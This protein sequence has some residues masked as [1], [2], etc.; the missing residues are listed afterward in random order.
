MAPESPWGAGVEICQPVN[1]LDFPLAHAAGACL[2]RGMKRIVATLAIGTAAVWADESGGQPVI[3][4]ANV[5]LVRPLDAA[6]LKR[7]AAGMPPRVVS[8]YST[9]SEPWSGWF[10][11][12]CE[13]CPDTNRHRNLSRL[14]FLTSCQSPFTVAA[15][16]HPEEPQGGRF[17]RGADGG[18]QQLTTTKDCSL[19]STEK[20]AIIVERYHTMDCRTQ[21]DGLMVPLPDAIR[22]ARFEI[23]ELTA[24]PGKD[25]RTFEIIGTEAAGNSVMT[26]EHSE[27]KGQVQLFTLLYRG[28]EAKPEALVHRGMLQRVV[29]PEG[30][31]YRQIRKEESAGPDGPLKVTQHAIESW[32]V[33]PDGTRKMVEKQVLV[34]PDKPADDNP[35]AESEHFH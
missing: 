24:G 16:V 26:A 4:K 13:S 27:R 8:I 12:A 29:W 31:G 2:A 11:F 3:E 22:Q 19:V 20:G 17:A 25:H 10:T 15:V 30:P 6:D 18:I 34:A 35:P 1:L 5:N 33:A 28:H 9:S 23:R 32:R 21:A 7:M 14:Q